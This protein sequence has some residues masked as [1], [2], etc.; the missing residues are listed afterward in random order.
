LHGDVTLDIAHAPV[1]RPDDGATGVDP[2]AVADRARA[3]LVRLREVGTPDGFATLLTG[4]TLRFPFDGAATAARTLALASH[5]DDADAATRAAAHLIGLGPG[6]TPAGD[7][8]IGGVFFARAMLD[9]AD[10]R[11]RWRAA[12]DIISARARQATHPISAVFLADL[13]AG[14]GHAPLHELARGLAGG[15]S[16]PTVLDA[17]RR[18]ARIGH[19]SGWDI[20]AGLLAALVPPACW[21]QGCISSS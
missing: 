14:R 6:L 21:H 11:E 10:S 17:A 12:G 20:L 2:H 18:L 16:P 4:Q 8:Y 19:S 7:D 1:W 5:H 13:I 15:A 9:R 3:F